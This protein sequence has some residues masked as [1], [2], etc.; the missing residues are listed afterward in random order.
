MEKPQDFYNLLRRARSKPEPFIVVNVEQQPEIVP[1]QVDFLSNANYKKSAVFKIQEIRE[2]KTS[3]D[4]C[5]VKHRPNYNGL[6]HKSIITQQNKK[7]QLI[8][9]EYQ[10]NEFYLPP[11]NFQGILVILFLS[12]LVFF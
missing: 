8:I 7:T 2:F 1:K 4:S 11:S 9:E 3:S 10:D 6:F 5:F 12:R